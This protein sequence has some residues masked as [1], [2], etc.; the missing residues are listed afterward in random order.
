MNSRLFVG[1]G[2][3]DITPLEPVPLRGYGNT[4]RRI[5]RI[6]IDRLKA[7]CLAF[8]DDA[9]STVLAFAL[10]LC[11]AADA[12]LGRMDVAVGKAVGVDPERVLLSCSHNHSSPDVGNR[13]Q[14]SI[15]RYL[16]YLEGQLIAAAKEAMAD[17][18]PA[19]LFAGS[20]QTAGLNHV[21]RYVMDDGSFGGDNYGDFKNHRP[22]RHESEAD[23]TLQ[24][25]RIE[26]AGKK[27]ILLANFQMH[28]HRMGGASDPRIT[29][30]VVGAFRS[31]MEHQHGCLFAYFTGGSGNIN[32]HSRIPEENITPDYAS[33]G[34]KLAEYAGTVEYR[35]LPAGPVEFASR[36]LELAVNHTTDPLLPAAEE[37]VRRWKAGESRDSLLPD[38]RAQGFNSPYHATAVVSRSKLGSALEMPIW[39]F[40]I[41]GAAFAAAPYEMFDTNGKEIKDASPYGMTFILTCTNAAFGYFPSALGFRNGGYSADT[42]RFLPGV[43]EST[44][45]EFIELL[46]TLPRE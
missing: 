29:A 1:F 5:S 11:S 14:E 28:P 46:N 19:R 44:A 22:V 41:G 13:E 20:T 35:E 10:D 8:S 42:C 4:S 15:P 3:A 16:D 37:L 39:A 45:Q 32:G 36:R 23:R 24:M 33:H 25:L 38:L 7:T 43:G 17:R 34:M 18:S 2:R 40:S 31:A 6:V 26:R 21:R 27:D 12:F 30:D 9:G